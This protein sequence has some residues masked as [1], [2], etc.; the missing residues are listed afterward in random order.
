VADLGYHAL[1]ID[2]AGA[3][4]RTQTGLVSV[5]EFRAALQDPS[6]DEL[7]LAADLAKALP[8]G[9]Q[10]SIA[11]TLQRS[12]GRLDPDGSD[13]L[14]L[15]A[16]VAA[17][18]LPLTLIAA[19]L[20][21]ADDLDE[22]AARRQT[23]RGVAQAETLSLASPT[24]LGTDPDADGD[25]T[26]EGGWV[27][28]ALVAR[29]MRFTDPDQRR[30]AALRTAAVAVL[31]QALQDI[32]DP[33]AHTSLRQVVPHARELARHPGTTEEAELLSWVARYDYERGD[34][35]S[36][37]RAE[38]QVLDGFRRL[39]GSEHPTTLSAMNNLALTL[40][41]LGDAAGAAALHRQVLDARRRLLGPEHPDTL[42]SMSNLAMTLR[43]L[44][45]A[46]G[47]RDLL[48]QAVHAYEQLLGP[49]HPNTLVLLHNLAGALVDL[50][51]LA[52]ARDLLQQ[53]ADAYRRLLGPEHPNTQTV[54]K[55]LIWVQHALAE[56]AP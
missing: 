21:H 16:V 7:E 9:H 53:A 40:L 8:G 49:E 32:V 54:T 24:R 11:A 43:A 3:A 52:G 48:L 22:Q 42:G 39:L 4:L 33:S 26:V 41:A 30:T 45:D 5:G 36:A 19:V 37:E 23:S 29:T 2:V 51:D 35:R 46:A 31:T 55:N 15:A 25:S 12:T 13:V 47:G 20:Q 10:A 27:V 28:H 14:R 1:A 56:P 18:P 50:G 38:R 6:Q 34:Y 17:A 44:G